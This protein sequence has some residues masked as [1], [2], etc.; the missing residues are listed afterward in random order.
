MREFP[1]KIFEICGICQKNHA[2]KNCP[3]FP[4][5][6]VVFQQ[7]NE[8]VEQAYFIATKEP[9]WPR[10]LGMNLEPSSFFNPY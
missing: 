10:P 5:L 3:S 7:N 2:T 9:W 6:K 1:L 8:D 4:T